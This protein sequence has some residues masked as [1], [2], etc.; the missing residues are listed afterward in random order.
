MARILVV[1][2]DVLNM[3]LAVML[4]AI[5]GHETLQAWNAEEGLRLAREYSPELVLM[6]IRL[7]G[8][9]G[10]TAT[11]L[12]RSSATTRDIKIV[13]VTARVMPGDRDATEAAG[14]NG[15]IAKPINFKEFINTVEQVLGEDRE[16]LTTHRLHRQDPHLISD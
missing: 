7:P 8:I 2:D 14:C 12:L 6:D 4:L 15:Y 5:A 11:R 9:D 10:L 13:A 1:E 16:A 3:K